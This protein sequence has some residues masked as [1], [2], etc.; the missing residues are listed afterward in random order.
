MKD[1]KWIPALAGAMM[2]LWAMGALLPAPQ[3]VAAAMA[4][5]EENLF[6]VETPAPDTAFSIEVLSVA[7]EKEEEEEQESAWT[8]WRGSVQMRST[9]S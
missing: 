8:G 7:E 5:V 2:L 4:P 1:G 3:P 6:A 9:R